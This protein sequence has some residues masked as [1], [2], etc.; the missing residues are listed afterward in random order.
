M[1][2]DRHGVLQ[3]GEDAVAGTEDYAAG[4]VRVSF[5]LIDNQGSPVNRPGARVWVATSDNGRP[6]TRTTAQLEPIGVPGESE[7]A[8]LDVTKIYVA[9]FAVP[10]PGIYTVVTETLGAKPVQAEL[11]IQVRKRPQAPAVGSKAIAS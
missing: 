1:L 10:R 9:H 2:Q 5:L 8:S 4:R 6:F 11:H 7:A 3:A